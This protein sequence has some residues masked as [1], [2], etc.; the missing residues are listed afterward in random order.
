MPTSS[1]IGSPPVDI[2]RICDILEIKKGGVLMFW[3]RFRSGAYGFRGFLWL[4]LGMSGLS[5]VS[6]GPF[7]AY[8]GYP[9]LSVLLLLCVPC[10]PGCLG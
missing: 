10:L 2:R 3:V 5:T 4:C 7:L 8:S 1:A 9:G 6:I